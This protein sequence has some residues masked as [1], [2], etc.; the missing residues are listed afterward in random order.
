MKADRQRAHR[1]G[2][3]AEK[4]AGWYLRGKGYRILAG[5]SRNALGEIDI[6]AKRGNTLAAIEVKAR[7]T[8]EQCEESVAP[9][10]QQRIARAMEMWLAQSSALAGEQ[11]CAIR[12]DVIWMTPWRWPRHIKDAWRP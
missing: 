1:W 8:F 11:N 9:W 3:N 2:I 6:L 4:L 5:R 7:K 12:F 10:K